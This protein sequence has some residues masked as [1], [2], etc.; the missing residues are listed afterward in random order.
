M[1]VKTAKFSWGYTPT[2]F[3]TNLTCQPMPH[4]A[5]LR[6]ALISFSPLYNIFQ[7]IN[8]SRFF[9]IAGKERNILMNVLED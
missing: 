1:K 9:L 8:Q 6:L 3:G 2:V 4:F 7:I 5:C